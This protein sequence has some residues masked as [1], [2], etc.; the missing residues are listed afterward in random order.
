MESSHCRANTQGRTCRTYAPQPDEWPSRTTK[1][2]RTSQ[3]VAN[4]ISPHNTVCQEWHAQ[5]RTEDKSVLVTWL[6][7]Q[8]VQ[9][10]RRRQTM[11]LSDD[12]HTR[13]RRTIMMS[14]EGASRH[15]SGRR[16]A[17]LMTCRRNLA[18]CG[19]DPSKRDKDRHKAVE[20][21]I[22]MAA[23]GMAHRLLKR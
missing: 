2:D 17:M 9:V 14:H 15:W 12:A 4:D 13:Q 22:G 23:H 10:G 1:P 18:Y 11:L 20:V 6:T 16:P 3:P 19:P 21:D 8:G 5:V 7:A